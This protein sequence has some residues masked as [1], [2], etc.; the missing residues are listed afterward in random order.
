M[1]ISQLKVHIGDHQIIIP[2]CSDE[3]PEIAR[4]LKMAT[5]ANAVI[6]I[7][8][9]QNLETAGLIGCLV[10]GKP[11]EERVPGT[12]ATSGM[13]EVLSRR[14]DTLE[15]MV[16][17]QTA[18]RHAN[19]IYVWQIAEKT[20]HD[21]S[22]LKDIGRRSV[23]MIKE[24]FKELGVELGQDLSAIKQHLPQVSPA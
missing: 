3:D 15:L 7:E 6:S 23:A 11:K 13:I 21:V 24:L 18:L 22:R 14:L 2:S 17:T 12:P 16:R 8:V 19:L 9:P 10:Y 5:T 20:N 4:L 1:K